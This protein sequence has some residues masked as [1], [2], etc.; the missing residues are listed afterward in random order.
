MVTVTIRKKRAKSNRL[1][2]GLKTL[3][4]FIFFRRPTKE[5]IKKRYPSKENQGRKKRN[6]EVHFL[7]KFVFGMA[8]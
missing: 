7:A 4:K 8:V 3:K 5:S 6:K 1:K 2:D